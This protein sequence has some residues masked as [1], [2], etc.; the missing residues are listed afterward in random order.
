M[1]KLV[2]LLDWDGVQM[3]PVNV[4]VE[5]GSRFIFILFIVNY[6]FLLKKNLWSK[7]AGNKKLFS[8]G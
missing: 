3:H 2:N 7:H 4:S 6:K 1:K 8:S 5:T